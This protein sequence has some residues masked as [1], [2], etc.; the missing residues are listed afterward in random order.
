MKTGVTVVEMND[1]FV[2]TVLT[3]IHSQVLVGV[4]CTVV[5]MKYYIQ[6]N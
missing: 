2:C 6:T 1:I 4:V 3:A 5:L